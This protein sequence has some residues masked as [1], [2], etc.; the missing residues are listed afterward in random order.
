MSISTRE[1]FAARL[2]A[3][4]IAKHLSINDVAKIAGVPKATAQGWLNGSHMPTPALRERFLAIAE[5]LG[6]ADQMPEGL[7]LDEWARI[8]PRLRSES[9]PYVGLRP[10]EAKDADFYYGRV[11]EVRRL[12]ETILALHEESTTGIIALIGASGS[13]KSSL[14]AAG[15]VGRE[16]VDGVLAGWRPRLLT[17]ETLDGDTPDADLVIVDQLEEYLHLPSIERERAMANLS[18]HAERGL[19]VVAL[20]SDFFAAAGA[21]P[22]LVDALE[23]PVLV[24]PLTRAELRDVIVAPATAVGVTVDDDLVHMLLNDVAPGPE[25][26]SV[27]TDVLPLLSNALLM[28]W[29][30]GT[31]ERMSVAD[32]RSVG[33]MAGA[34][35]AL[36]EEVFNDLDADGQTRAQ[37]IFLRLLGLTHGALTRHSVRLDELGPEDRAVMDAFVA[38]RM[39]T[40][41]GD[42]V[43]ISHEAL[44]RHWARLAGWIDAHRAELD[45][46]ARLR[47]AAELWEDSEHDPN[48][49]IPVQRLPMFTD[50]MDDPDKQMLLGTSERD[51]LAASEKHF[52]SALEEE[53]RMS[54][55]LRRQR[56][57]ALT[58]AAV[59]TLAA[60]GAGVSFARGEGFRAEAVTARND[61]ESRQV[62]VAARSLRA[63]SPNLVAQMALVSLSLADT[64]EAR[65][66]VLDAEALDAPLRWTGAPNAVLAVSPDARVVARADG[67]GTVTVWHGSELSTSPGAAVSVDAK[68]GSLLAVALATIGDREVMAVG[69]TNVRALWDVTAEPRL[70]AEIDSPSAV[71]AAAFD[72]DSTKAVF[73]DASGTISVYD[74]A[75]LAAP[76]R[77]AAVA[78]KE[79]DP[80][81]Q[82]RAVALDRRG[83]L[84][85]GGLVGEIDRWRLGPTPKELAPIEV[86]TSATK[87]PARVQALAVTNGGERLAAGIAG[88]EVLRWTVSDDQQLSAEPSL[89]A[90]SSYINALSFSPDESQLAVASSDQTVSI[91]DSASGAELR[92][93]VTPAIQT[94]VGFAQDGR[95]VAVGT[96]GT[97]LVWTSRSPLWKASGSAVYNLAS[98]GARWLAAGGSTDGITLWRLDGDPAR[99]P[100]PVV[101]PLPDGDVQRGAVGV[102]PNG[103]FLVGA[104][105]HGQVLTWPLTEAGA[106]PGTAYASGVSNVIAY[107]TV[108]PDSSMVAAME[109]GGNHVILFRADGQGRLTQLATVEAS[110]PQLVGFSSDNRTLA[111]AQ[112]DNSIAFWSL[113]DPTSPKQVGSI[114]GLATMP[115]TFNLAPKSSRI[116]IGESSGGV[117]LWDFG[118]PAKPTLLRRWNDPASSMYSLAFSPDERWLVGTSGDDLIWGWD[119]ASDH[120]EADFALSGEVGRPWDVR[121]I[122]DGRRFA[123]SGSTGA[124]RVWVAHVADAATQL[125]GQ[126]GTPLTQDEW[127]RYL[128]GI[129]PRAVC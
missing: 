70:L 15:L 110:T 111:I 94:G 10:F 102:A 123:V 92:R 48:V 41:S 89:T 33:G 49:L 56:R 117:S 2:N 34:V 97:L 62:A 35:E 32:Y 53:R 127:R 71:T 113:A 38:A 82:V 96:D 106:G 30:A 108:S 67:T 1:A 69:G 99:A 68:G 119:L 26:A 105:L 61:A 55:R 40:V 23:R 126:I 83:I 88:S 8:E 124:V 57:L 116:A 54:R 86:L 121:F 107:T 19:V 50:W 66:M 75:D 21:E 63:K 80:P 36:A 52:S 77:V 125:C 114:S 6:L 60:V 118:D 74:L 47:R 112:V 128:P 93:M 100:Q 84:Y 78:L 39:L 28:T 109:Y 81:E 115:A 3:A 85:A 122:D 31:G 13:G 12:A 101:P 16:C 4:R 91:Y 79:P 25:Q 58:L 51:F 37:R 24:S 11:P 104:T 129:E 20:R 95:P 98:D 65:S 22:L 14:L 103:S 45:S 90:F 64:Q 18:R 87:L 27:S 73:G 5:A 29:A 42:E 59:T 46:L 7:W 9:A 44:L 120:S 43:R 72:P 76:R 17:P